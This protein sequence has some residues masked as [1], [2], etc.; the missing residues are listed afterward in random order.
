VIN[1]KYERGGWLK[2]KI[3]I[4]FCGDNSLTDVRTEIKSGL[5]E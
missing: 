4:L 5:A 1:Q 2:V 3:H